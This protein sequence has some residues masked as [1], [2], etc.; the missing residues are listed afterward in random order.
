MVV[1]RKKKKNV[2]TGSFQVC[3]A[4]KATSNKGKTCSVNS[5][6]LTAAAFLMNRTML[7]RVKAT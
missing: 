7:K 5:A 4:A 6:F 2:R 1:S 3:I